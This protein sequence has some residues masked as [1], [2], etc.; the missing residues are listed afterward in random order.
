MVIIN[1][2]LPAATFSAVIILAHNTAKWQGVASGATSNCY[3]HT[4]QA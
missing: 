1:F 4:V 2:D 3:A